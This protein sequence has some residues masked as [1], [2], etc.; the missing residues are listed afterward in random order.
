MVSSKLRDSGTIQSMQLY[1]ISTLLAVI[2]TLVYTQGKKKVSLL[3]SLFIRSSFQSQS[4]SQR[5]LQNGLISVNCLGAL[6][7]RLHNVKIV[8]D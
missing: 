2:L 4:C 3:S 5:K 8:Y 7:Y 1:I 6:V